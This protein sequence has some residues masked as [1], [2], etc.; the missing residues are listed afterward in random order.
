MYHS[1]PS[2]FPS[3]DDEIAINESDITESD[4]DM[5]FFKVGIKS[6]YKLILVNSHKILALMMLSIIHMAELCLWLVHYFIEAINNVYQLT[7]V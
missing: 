4:N 7:S 6:E 3:T 1:E 2:K 5:G